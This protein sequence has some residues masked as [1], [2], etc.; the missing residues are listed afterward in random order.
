MTPFLK[1]QGI[2][3]SDIQ[4]LV[5]HDKLKLELPL[6]LDGEQIVRNERPRGTNVQRPNL[7]CKGDKL[8]GS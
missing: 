1:A 4:L 3:I 7:L 8:P 6:T 5:K 2:H